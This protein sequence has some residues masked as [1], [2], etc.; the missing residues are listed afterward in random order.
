[1]NLTS[2]PPPFPIC[3]MQ[4]DLS[5]SERAELITYNALPGSMTKDLNARV[6]LQQNNEARENFVFFSG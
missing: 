3:S 6:Y 5:F 4:G 1:M 2:L